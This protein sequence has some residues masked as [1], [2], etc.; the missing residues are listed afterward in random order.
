MPN[1][2]CLTPNTFKKMLNIKTQKA[3]SGVPIWQSKTLEN[4]S[5]GF[6]LEDVFPAGEV[7]PAGT[8]IEADEATRK[9]KVAKIAILQAQA[10]ETETNY[11]VL[12][13]HLL[14]VGMEVKFGSASA[15]SITKV[16]K[17]NAD[18]DILT[19]SATL[20]VQIESGQAVLEES[21]NVSKIKGLLYEAVTIGANKLASVSVT[22]RGTV[23]ARRIPPVSE[24]VK[25]QLPNIVF[26][27][28]Y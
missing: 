10:S 25:K 7:I 26:S 28:S 1:A 13:G 4:A 27:E 23:Y 3:T 8:P 15:Q 22:I 17:S 19:L 6:S 11:K 21:T 14:Q 20:G 12:K 16:D 5:G 9:A 24:E 2:F 18:Y